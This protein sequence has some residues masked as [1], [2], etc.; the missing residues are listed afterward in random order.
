M[1]RMVFINLP[2]ADL[3]K[4]KAFYSALGFTINPQ[5]TDETAACVVISEEIHVM[6]LT[7]PKLLQFTPQGNEV[8]DA[9]KATEVLVCLSCQSRDEVDEVASKALSAGGNSF[10]EP[11]DYGFMYSQ[12]FQD[13][14]GHIWELAF[15][16]MAAFPTGDAA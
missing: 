5:F 14:D 1:S 2:V 6:L 3:D 8:C 7:H 15:M 11:Q 10:R 16:D 4:S 13:L 12:S 9:R